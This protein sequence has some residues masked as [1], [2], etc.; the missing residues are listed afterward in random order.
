MESSEAERNP[1]DSSPRSIILDYAL[2]LPA[3]V[4]L[5]H[6]GYAAFCLVNSSRNARRRIFPTGVFGNSSRNSTTF[7]RL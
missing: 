3:A 4:R 6:P 1:G 2:G 5:L 7:G